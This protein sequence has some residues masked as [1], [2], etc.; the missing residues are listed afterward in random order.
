MPLPRSDDEVLASLVEAGLLRPEGAG[1]RTTRRWQAAMS[2]AAFQL[3]G[4]GDD[5][6]GGDLRAP[7]VLALLELEGELPD[8][9]LVRLVRLLGPIEARELDPRRHSSVVSAP[10]AGPQR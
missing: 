5:G 4:A 6:S 7:I 2:R 9:D 10:R 1:H 8:E 3:L